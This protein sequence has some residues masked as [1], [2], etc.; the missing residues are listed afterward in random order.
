MPSLTH[1]DVLRNYRKLT[2]SGSGFGGHKVIVGWS[3]GFLPRQS[4]HW[5]RT[6]CKQW[7][8]KLGLTWINTSWAN[9][10]LIKKGKGQKVEGMPSPFAHDF[11][12]IRVSSPLWTMCSTGSRLDGDSDP[13]WTEHK[14]L[15]PSSIS[16]SVSSLGKT[17]EV[18]LNFLESD[19]FSKVAG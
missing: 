3:Y 5:R 8:S 19:R 18:L 12:G 13:A 15:L 17:Q 16:Y 9:P 1:T 11:Y 2:Y 7:R 14:N 10:S 6:V 4:R